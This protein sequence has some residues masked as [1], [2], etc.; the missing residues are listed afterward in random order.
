VSIFCHQRIAT[1]SQL[2]QNFLDLA[3]SVLLFSDA[4]EKN[5]NPENDA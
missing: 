2:V 5:I 1:G 4:K 3:G